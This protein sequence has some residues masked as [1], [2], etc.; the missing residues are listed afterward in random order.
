[1]ITCQEMLPEIKTRPE[2]NFKAVTDIKPLESIT[3]AHH[4]GLLQDSTG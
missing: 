2:Q 4:V 3:N 1:M